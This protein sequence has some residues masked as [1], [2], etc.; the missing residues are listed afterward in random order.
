MSTLVEKTE[1]RA[2]EMGA[3]DRDQDRD[4]ISLEK[5]D[6]LETVKPLPGLSQ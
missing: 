5:E 2:G 6:R 3:L 1:L 4:S